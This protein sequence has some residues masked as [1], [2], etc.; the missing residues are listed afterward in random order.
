MHGFF[1][2]DNVRHEMLKSKYFIHAQIILNKKKTLQN[3]TV[4]YS[5]PYCQELTTYETV[6]VMKRWKCRQAEKKD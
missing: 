6:K 2:I 4:T 1:L 5:S 3:Y